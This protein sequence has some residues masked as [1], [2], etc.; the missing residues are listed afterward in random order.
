MIR[1]II[2]DCFGVLYADASHRFYEDNVS[3]EE[4]HQQ[5]V[6]LNKQSDYGLITRDEWIDSVSEIMQL[7]KD[8][9][10]ENIQREQV[11]NQSLLDY[12][13]SLR[14]DYKIGMLSNIGVSVMDKFFSADERRDYF[15]AVVLSSEVGLTKPHPEIFK[16]MAER[17]NCEPS[18]CIMIDDLEDNCAGADAAG[19][20]A[21]AYKTNQQTMS[22]LRSL[23]G[24]G[25]A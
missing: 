6:D 8:F 9:V 12:A 3:S 18:E 16:L 17:L 7:D 5:L 14:Q 21:I 22:A 10:A 24:H 19:M 25:N 2:F 15:D 1:A 20:Q 4:E 13:V 11:R 23:L